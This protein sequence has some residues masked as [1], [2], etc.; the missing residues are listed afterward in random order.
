MKSHNIV[1]HAWTSMTQHR[2]EDLEK[3]KSFDE[4]VKAR[5]EADD[6]A[7]NVIIDMDEILVY[8]DLIPGQTDDKTGVKSVI[9]STS[10]ADLK[11]LDF[12][13]CSFRFR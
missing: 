6:F 2:P 11:K 3:L 12:N 9:V 8:F 1:L 7:D 10:G 13:P 4:F 5:R